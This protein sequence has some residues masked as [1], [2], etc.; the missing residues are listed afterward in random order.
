[1]LTGA[2]SSRFQCAGR[3]KETVPVGS[4]IKI[5]STK[6]DTPIKEEKYGRWLAEIYLP[7]GLNFS[8]L[9]LEKG[10]ATLWQ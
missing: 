4:I 2:K 6:R 8:D 1:M 9:M 10:Y 5:Q 7:G 3:R